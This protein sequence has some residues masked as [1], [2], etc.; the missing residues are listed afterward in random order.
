MS[1][2][3]NIEIS[4]SYRCTLCVGTGAYFYG[5]TAE[6]DAINH[7]REMHIDDPNRERRVEGKW[8]PPWTFRRF[9]TREEAEAYQCVANKTTFGI[10]RAK[11]EWTTPG[12]YLVTEADHDDPCDV[13]P[14]S[15][16]L[17]EVNKEVQSARTLLRIAEERMREQE[18]ALATF[19]ASVSR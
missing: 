15:A 1:L 2:P 13:L 18:E 12:W 10:G 11:C 7:A 16:A 9:D 6:A 8:Y 5:D 4:M 14:M 17:K 19:V 3:K